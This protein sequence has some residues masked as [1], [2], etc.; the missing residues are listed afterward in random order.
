M[1]AIDL[2]SGIG[3]WTLGFK[4]AGIP[5]AASYEWW[6]DANLTHNNNFG[7][8]HGE[9]DIRT[10][11]LGT[12]PER[13]TI[14]YVVGSPPCTQFSYSNR[15]GNGDIQDG[16]EDIKKFLKVV[17]YLQPRYWA[18]ENV[19][20]VAKI[21]A[22][23]IKSKGK[24]ARFKEL[25]GEIRVYN[26]ADFGVPQDR[27]RMIAGRLPFNLLDS[28][29]ANVPRLRLSDVLNS[30]LRAPYLDPIYGVEIPEA[31][32]TD[33][34]REPRLSAEEER[35]NLEAKTHH[36]VYNRMSFPDNPNRPSRTITALCTRVSR[37]SIIIRD[38]Q[39][40]LRRLTVRERAGIQS[41]PMNYQFF[42]STYPNK[43]KMIGNAV[44]PLLTF[45]IA[46]SMLETPVGNL[47]RPNQV[48]PERLELS[49][50]RAVSH[51]PDNQGAKYPWKR[52]F[53]LAIP[54]LRFGSG[55]RFDLK[56]FHAKD[57]QSTSW[58]INFYYGSSKDIK[59]KQLDRTI[60]EKALRVS[61]LEESEEFN[62]LF[63]QLI[64]FIGTVDE[65][66]LQQNWTNQDRNLMGPIK[67]IDTLAGY[68]QMFRT[69]LEELDKEYSTGI[70]TFIRKEF[71]KKVQKEDDKKKAK[72]GKDRK[73]ENEKEKGRSDLN[74]ASSHAVEI[75]IGMLIGASFNLIMQNERVR[76]RRA[77]VRA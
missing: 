56:N 29:M 42:G 22:K 15:G 32:L 72:K 54:G 57:D 7:S 45:Y 59:K 21:L 52:S 19:P 38:D 51:N 36:P 6:K 27:K 34:V 75:F 10:L 37:E 46:Q 18:M 35:I 53:W 24:L 60:L 33:H 23:E 8:H 40:D 70:A 67:L 9:T 5:V 41:F 66:A 43:L 2:Y 64:S 31:D 11:E 4:M 71:E 1:A 26:S 68:V 69:R 48:P 62:E 13:G 50:E 17:E 58:R 25:F 55:V 14:E 63:R 73:E 77:R 74:K 12:L 47:L 65:Q 76:I 3:G 20:R 16:L 39:G 44:P 61:G 28:Y 49:R 30:L